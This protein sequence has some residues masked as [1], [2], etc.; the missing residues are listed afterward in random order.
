MLVIIDEREIVKSGYSSRFGSEGVASA[1]FCPLEFREWVT[2]A[3]DGDLGAVEAF[4]LGDCRDRQLFPK[5]IDA[6][7]KRGFLLSVAVFRLSYA[8]GCYR[9]NPIC[10]DFDAS[11]TDPILN[12]FMHTMRTVGLMAAQGS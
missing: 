8:G 7:E 6:V 1:G 9:N 10:V 12:D 4:L 2:T 11:W 3:A 5:M